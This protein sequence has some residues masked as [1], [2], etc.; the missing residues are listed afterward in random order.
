MAI[1]QEYETFA[2]KLCFSPTGSA[3]FRKYL[4][5][6]RMMAPLAVHIADGVLSAPLVIGGFAGAAALSAPGLVAVRDDEV[7]RLGL[8]TAAFFVASS[9][10]IPLPPT[11]VHLLLNGLVGIVLGVRSGLAI[12]VGLF[13]QW[14]FL[15]HGGLSTVGINTCVV[16]APAMAT[17]A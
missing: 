10:H 11:S 1:R 2:V 8:M 17:A 14:A 3:I 7:P 12:L 13:F 9:I 16:A 15:S 5:A 6:L 4:R